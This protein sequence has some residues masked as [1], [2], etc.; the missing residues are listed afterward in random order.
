[1]LDDTSLFIN[2]V[3][4]GGLSSAARVLSLPVATVTRR[5]QKLEQQ[6]GYQLLHRSARQFALTQEGEVYYRAY[7]DLVGQFEQTRQQLS[8]DM[9]QVRGKLKVLAPINIS[10]GFLRPMWL[11]FARR[12]PEIQLEV[13]LSNQLQDMAASKADIAV[14]VGPQPDSSLHQ[15]KLGEIEKILVASPTYLA[16]I[17]APQHPSDIKNHRVIGTTMFSKWKLNNRE[18]G[19]SLEVF[20]RFSALFN[21]TSFAKYLACDSQGISLLP[22]TEVKAE[23]ESGDLVRILPQWR[24]EARGI[25]A[26]WPSGR[27]LNEKAKRLREYLQDYI[28]ANLV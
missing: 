5:L 22:M 19:A 24:G 23:I 28:D 16:E 3:Q 6:L 18:T 26:V 17:G 9:K 2:I 8:A 10:H 27:L 20:P 15:K 12:Y 11:G 25:Y 14:R 7:T 13:I 1:M 4:H 21:D